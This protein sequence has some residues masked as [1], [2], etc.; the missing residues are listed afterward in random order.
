VEEKK[1]KWG[2]KERIEKLGVEERIESRVIEILYSSSQPKG[3]CSKNKLPPFST[4]IFCS[5]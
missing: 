4:N 2:G 1:K 5:L 3:K